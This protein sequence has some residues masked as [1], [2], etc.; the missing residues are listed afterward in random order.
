[1]SINTAFCC[2]KVLLLC[3]SKQSLQED[4][5]LLQD[6]GEFNNGSQCCDL[7]KQ[8][9]LDFYSLFPVGSSAH[10]FPLLLSVIV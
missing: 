7:V 9:P 5:A 3:V 10:A 1:M 2:A 6:T 4:S 8:N